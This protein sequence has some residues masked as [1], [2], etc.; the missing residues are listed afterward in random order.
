MTTSG[1]YDARLA[2]ELR[3]QALMRAAQDGNNAAYAQLLSEI[4]PTL[5]RMVAYKWPGTGDVE[6]VVQEILLSV[7]TVRHTYDPAR[8]FMPWL[9]TIA[10][11][12]TI[13]AARRRT[14]RSANETTVD[15]MPETFSGDQT[16]TEQA[17][18]GAGVVVA[19]GVRRHWEE[20]RV[21]ESQ[22][23]RGRKGDARDVGTKELKA[24]QS[25]ELIR[26][27]AVNAPPV[28][29][30][31]YPAW[32][33]TTWFMLSLAY[34]AVVVFAMGLRP[35]ISARVAE[36]RFLVE[37]FSALL[38]AMMAAAAA[39][40]A[41][42]PG[43]PLWERLAP[44][45]FLAVWAASLGAGCWRDWVRFGPAGLSVQPDFAHFPAIM[46]AGFAPAILIFVMI[47]SGTPI[48]QYTTNGL[49]TLAAAA[50][51]AATLRLFHTQDA[52]IMVLIWQFGSVMALTGFGALFGRRLLRWRT[53]DLGPNDSEH[54]FCR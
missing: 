28:R 53:V 5:R 6:D 10:T 14:V 25:E 41:G 39:L 33:A 12:R 50:L 23:A 22:C 54:D 21:A 16:K 36:P 11:R 51:G 27:L 37:I 30:L 3:W 49:T 43:R 29:R 48:A 7:H 18:E 35:D 24:M 4:L 40:C 17:D 9:M 32:R 34:A 46:I 45:P 42:C 2:R 1:G 8:P 47:R 15:V 31:A 44:F 19:R 26:R 20:R 52:G 38:T 13:D